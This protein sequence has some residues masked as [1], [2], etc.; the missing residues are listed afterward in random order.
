MKKTT[1]LA[2]TTT[3]LLSA[4][5]TPPAVHSHLARFDAP[6][7]ADTPLVINY[8]LGTNK[9]NV[10]PKDTSAPIHDEEDLYLG[11]DISLSHGFEFNF[12]VSPQ[13]PTI[14]YGLKYQ[15]SGDSR[16]NARPGNVSHAI[17]L[18][19]HA[20]AN[21]EG[22]DGQGNLY[23]QSLALYDIAWIS[24]YRLTP[25]WLIYGSL[26]YQHG[27]LDI[28]YNP[29]HHRSHCQPACL[30]GT[31]YEQTSSN[32]GLSL[33]TEYQPF[34]YVFVTLEGTYLHADWYNRDKSELALNA[35]LTVQFAPEEI[36]RAIF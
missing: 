27:N 16:E 19:Y 30:T 9:T 32:Y 11:A 6:E 4:C 34:Q 28:S 15:L 21:G 13:A 17:T 29:E 23:T 8:K 14:G 7:V 22:N 10:I 3:L 24:G 36:L 26:F 35:A 2:L 1:P 33:S 25:Q 5:S 12:E 18:A 20:S 31:L